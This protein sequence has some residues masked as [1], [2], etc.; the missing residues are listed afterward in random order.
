MG[1][2]LARIAGSFRVGWCRLSVA[3]GFVGFSGHVWASADGVDWTRQASVL[4]ER[5][6]GGADIAVATH[7]GSLF[8]FDDGARG[9][10]VQEV[11][12]TG[13]GVR[14][15]KVGNAEP[16][17]GEDGEVVSRSDPKMVSFGGSLWLIGG[18]GDGGMI[19]RS[20]DGA[21]WVLANEGARF[22]DLVEH[23]IAVHEVI[24]DTAPPLAGISVAG[25]ASPYTVVTDSQTPL[26]M[27]TLSLAGGIGAYRAT[28]V[29]DGDYF[30]M[31]RMEEERLFVSVTSMAPAFTTT[32]MTLR[33][34]DETP[35]G[36]VEREIVVLFYPPFVFYDPLLV[37]QTIAADFVGAVFLATTGGRAMTVDY[38]LLAPVYRAEGGTIAV[39]LAGAT[40]A[41][42]E[43]LGDG[44]AVTMTIVGGG[45]GD[46]F[47]GAGELDFG[48]EGG[49]GDGEFVGVAPAVAD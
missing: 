4:V 48:F 15:A 38:S 34:G 18:G 41:L 26:L 44:E 10:D 32:T 12:A 20:A 30:V 42:G 2:G 31:E 43:G 7:R 47:G 28:L 14:W 17:Y 21:R 39:S 6:I 24:P 29:A 13:D 19:W 25:L 36:T 22:G 1:C 49:G 8:V 3:C 23:E 46:E 35:D 27:A 33:V 40:V 37:T 45:C 11:W 5:D 16:S 9:F